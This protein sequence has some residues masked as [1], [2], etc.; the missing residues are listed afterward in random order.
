MFVIEPFLLIDEHTDFS[1]ASII[2]IDLG[3]SIIIMVDTYLKY[4]RKKSIND[5]C[6]I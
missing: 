5:K 4:P 6:N 1:K 3:N 2:I